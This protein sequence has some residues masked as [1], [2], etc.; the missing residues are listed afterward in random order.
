MSDTQASSVIGF[1]AGR[2]TINTDAQVHSRKNVP[3]LFCIAIDWILNHMSINPWYQCWCTSA[4]RSR[5]RKWN[6]T[7]FVLSL[8]DATESLSC[9]KFNSSSVL[10]LR[11]S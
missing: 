5:L 1:A 7:F 6:C 3:V 2:S 9:F 8:P 4:H 11:V 10:G